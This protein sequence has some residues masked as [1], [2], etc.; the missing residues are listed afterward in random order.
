M[1]EAAPKISDPKAPEASLDSRKRGG[2]KQKPS[3]TTTSFSSTKPQKENE[4][5]VLNILKNIQSVQLQTKSEFESLHFPK[6]MREKTP[7]VWG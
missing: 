6:L 5:V 7:D 3:T 1:A 4:D 2:T